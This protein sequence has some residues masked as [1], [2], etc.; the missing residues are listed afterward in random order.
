MDFD[1]IASGSINLIGCSGPN[2]IG[3]VAITEFLE[4]DFAW[5]KYRADKGL[6]ERVNIKKIN[7]QTIYQYNYQDT[8]NRVWLERELCSL[9]EAQAKI[10]DFKVKQKKAYVLVQKNCES[11]L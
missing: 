2:S 9:E 3:Y 8:F 4:G 5:I 10:H 1:Y 6:L 11:T 7:F